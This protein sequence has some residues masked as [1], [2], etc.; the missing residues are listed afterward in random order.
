MKPPITIEDI[1]SNSEYKFNEL[2]LDLFHY[3]VENNPVYNQ[4]LKLIDK[5]S[6][7]PRNFSEIP[8]LPIQFFKTHKVVSSD[9]EPEALFESSSTTGTETSK[10]Y[11]ADLSAYESIA[12]A[13]FKSITRDIDSFEIA[14]LLPNYLERGNSSLVYMVRHFMQGNRQPERFY[15]YN[16]DALK[17]WLENCTSTPIVFAVSFALLDFA[18]NYTSSKHFIVFETGGMKG[19]KE[20]LTKGEFY[21][22]IKQSFPNAEIRSEYGMTELTSQAY[23]HKDLH[24]QP[25]HWMKVLPRLDNDP[26][27]ASAHGKRA[28]LNIIDLANINSCCFIATDDLGIVHTNGEFEVLGRLDH[29][30]LRGCSLLA[31]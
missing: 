25:P 21:A 2:A 16:H 11:I 15:L 17:D 22:R 20:E 19:R 27:S 30:D 29:S 13:I 12:S 8:F 4:Y 10:H 1:V 23:S 24:F 14:G 6:F 7:K 31:V 18:E 28:A 5:R 3:Q 9:F 26:L